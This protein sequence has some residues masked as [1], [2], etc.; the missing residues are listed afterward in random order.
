M[1]KDFDLH[2]NCGVTSAL[3]S[4]T[5]STDTTT[6]GVIIDTQGF[7]G[8][9]FILQSGTI[10]DGAYTVAMQEGDV[11][12]LS[13]AATVAT[14][15]VLGSITFAATEDNVAKRVGYIGKKRYVRIRVV[16]TGTSSGGVFSGTAVKWGANHKPV[17][18]Q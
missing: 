18:N 3:N 17:A 10:T 16:S 11:S 15:E 7:R 9:E 4:Q 2:N 12:D 5:I 13:D 1:S 8:V 14:D 6:N